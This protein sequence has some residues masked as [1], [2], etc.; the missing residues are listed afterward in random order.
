MEKDKIKY[1]TDI[2]VQCWTKCNKNINQLESNLKEIDDLSNG[3]IRNFK[4]SRSLVIAQIFFRI[5]KLFDEYRK[6][7]K[8]R[9]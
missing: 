7:L 3:K 4:R 5:E 9:N 8:S 1:L 2:T 6:V